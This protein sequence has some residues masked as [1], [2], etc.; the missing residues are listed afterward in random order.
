MCGGERKKKS[1]APDWIRDRITPPTATD[2]FAA[3]RLN[4]HHRFILVHKQT[5]H[6]QGVFLHCFA[7]GIEWIKRMKIMSINK[8]NFSVPRTI[9]QQANVPSH[10]RAPP[11]RNAL[12]SLPP[13]PRLNTHFSLQETSFFSPYFSLSSLFSQ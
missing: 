9:V 13:K 7:V 10:H 11:Q 1:S 3:D 12:S 6:L 2:F 4:G 5:A 8:I